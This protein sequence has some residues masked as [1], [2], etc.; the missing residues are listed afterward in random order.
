MTATLDWLRSSPLLG[1]FLTLAGYK[2]GLEA[3]RLTRGHPLAQPVVVAIVFIALCL[4]ALRIDYDRYLSGASIIGFFLGPATVALAIPLHRQVHHLGRML[5]PMIVA[6]PCG[7]LISIGTAVL[8]VKALG[9]TRLLQLTM[10]PKAATTPVSI[11]VSHTIGGLPP[12]TAVLTIIAGIIG[13]IAAPGVLSMIGVHDRR[14]RGLAIG[15]VSHGIGTSRAMHDHPTEGAFAGL[16]MGLT[17][18]CV[19]VLTPI[20]LLVL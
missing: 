10:A 16:S 6:L 5:R 2:L 11:A 15:A 14:A 3:R 19:S 1:V 9:G 8:T 17:A 12:L 18:L 20:L 7:A 13:A 4:S